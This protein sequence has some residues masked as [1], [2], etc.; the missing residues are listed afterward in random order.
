MGSGVTQTDSGAGCVP[1]TS[2]NDL[3]SILARSPQ[4]SRDNAAS[5]PD[6]KA[7]S[8][9]M[10]E[11]AARPLD[12]TSSPSPVLTEPSS[13]VVPTSTAATTMAATAGVR[14]G[15]AGDAGAVTGGGQT[16]LGSREAL[17][18]LASKYGGS[19]VE[20]AA[21]MRNF[22]RRGL[23]W[24]APQSGSGHHHGDAHAHPSFIRGESVGVRLHFLAI[25]RWAHFLFYEC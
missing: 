3:D 5:S 2:I 14:A 12:V 4:P 24:A 15:C 8:P 18:L 13:I 23:V 17:D 21:A 10:S 19:N 20:L 7:K 1:A 22:E 9:V 25:L 11:V 6:P 16:S